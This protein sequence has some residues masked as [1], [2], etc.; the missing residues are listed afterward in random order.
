MTLI[1][2]AVT[3]RERTACSS[4]KMQPDNSSASWSAASNGTFSPLLVASI[5]HY[6]VL[7]E[8]RMGDAGLKLLTTFRQWAE[9]RGA[10]ELSVGINSRVE[11]EKMD[12][13]LR[14]LGFQRT[15]GNYSL[16]LAVEQVAR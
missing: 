13:F 3:P 8:K 16:P 2:T 5:I 15:G 11:I 14:K 9:N 6:D 1:S 4:L 10:F 7:P 12:R